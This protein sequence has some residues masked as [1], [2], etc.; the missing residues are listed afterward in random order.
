MR[1][2]GRR[3]TASAL[4]LLSLLVCT[5]VPTEGQSV[6]L[7]GV[8][9]V[10]YVSA[11][12]LREDSVPVSATVGEGL[13]RQTTDG[14]AVRC[15]D[16]A[17]SCR[18]LAAGD[19]LH[20][21]P[22][23]QDVSVAVWGLGRG[24]RVHAQLRLR[25]GV[26]G[27]EALWPRAEDRVE[28]LEAYLEVSRRAGRLRLG[29]LW[30]TSGLGAYGYDGASVQLGGS[31]LLLDVYGGWSLVR[32]L[33]E[34]LTDEA[35]AALE[36]FAPDA[37]AVLLGARLQVR[38]A[39]GLR[40]SVGYQREIRSDRLGLY[41]ER[42]TADVAWRRGPIALEGSGDADV[43]A[44]VFNH[45]RLDARLRPAAHVELDVFAR[46]YRPYF[47]LWTIWGAFAPV[48]FNEA[49]LGVS[50]DRAEWPIAPSLEVSR[51]RYADTRAE[52]TFAPQRRDGWRMA[53][54]LAPRLP[55][56]WSAIARYGADVGAGAARSE[57]ALR[58]RRELT[59]GAHIGLE[60]SVFDRASDFMVTDGVVAGAALDG[61]VR[62]SARTRAAANIMTYRHIGADAR[63]G[64][65]WTQTRALLQ[66][67]WTLG[68][69]PGSPGGGR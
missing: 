19:V 48:G 13:A 37:R 42:A 25:P 27:D 1:R 52:L 50:A 62:L 60:A 61:G 4:W 64:A 22:L 41:S 53:A 9:T 11:R 69:E 2:R 63:A 45:L 15:S 43:A 31:V 49:G 7:T 66:L 33:D 10:R 54:A 6:R 40:G 17:S 34:P 44:R 46:H 57:A 21:V 14:I 23:M 5:A 18:Y 56:G 16:E 26:L 29:R 47:D 3:R 51:R 68:P 24:V 55:G 32:G 20:A 67:E 65:D 59:D 8:T 28:A 30:Q 12:A 39:A 35:L 36:P 58:V 38:G